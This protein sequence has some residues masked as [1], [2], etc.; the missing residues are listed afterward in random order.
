MCFTLW[1]Y[2]IILGCM[3]ILASFLVV[4][5]HGLLSGTATMDFGGRKGA[6]T[7]VGIVDGFVYLGTGLQSVSIGFIASRDWSYWP[8]FLI[9][10]CILAVFM[11]T[12]IWRAFPNAKRKG[13]A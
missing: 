4:G 10:F 5:I 7:A 6:A 1:D 2:P 8:V 13:S 11:S 3:V 12:K 9:P